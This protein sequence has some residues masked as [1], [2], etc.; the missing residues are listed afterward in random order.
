MSY[1]EELM[2][3][4]LGPLG[5]DPTHVALRIDAQ[6]IKELEKAHK[7]WSAAA[8]FYDNKFEV[9]S[10]SVKFEG[11]EYRLFRKN[12]GVLDGELW[13]GLVDMRRVV[14][15]EL[16]FR[17]FSCVKG[18]S[19]EIES[20]CLP[21]NQFYAAARKYRSYAMEN[22]LMKAMGDV[23]SPPSSGSSMSL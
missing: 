5:H 15:D 11:F 8:D 1:Y 12:E 22:D 3:G 13:S 10:L 14:I 23:G 19:R 21:F 18:S 17:F 9:Y 6:T 4:N 20:A 7:A 2:L 16:G